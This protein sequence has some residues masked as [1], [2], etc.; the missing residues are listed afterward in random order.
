MGRRR[1]KRRRKRRRLKRRKKIRKRR[2]K[3]RRRERG[4]RRRTER[5]R[6]I[7]RRSVDG[8]LRAGAVQKQTP[9]TREVRV[10]VLLGLPADGKAVGTMGSGVAAEVAAVRKRRRKVARGP[11]ATASAAGGIEV[12]LLRSLHCGLCC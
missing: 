1:R 6:S 7:R 2:G 8:T 3:R 4:K 9:D 10:A 11:G 12:G 5:R